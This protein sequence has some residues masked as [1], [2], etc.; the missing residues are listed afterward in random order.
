MPMLWKLYNNKPILT[1]KAAEHNATLHF[2]RNVIGSMYYTPVTFLNSQN[3]PITSYAHELALSV[4]FESGFQHFA[5][6]K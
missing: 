6:R 3:P 4:V 2:T 1:S 5:A